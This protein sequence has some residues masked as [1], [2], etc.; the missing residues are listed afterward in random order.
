MPWRGEN[1]EP[2]VCATLL[3]TFI[4]CAPQDTEPV[5]KDIEIRNH[6]SETGT[7]NDANSKRIVTNQIAAP[8]ADSGAP[9]IDQ[10]RVRSLEHADCDAI[11]P[12][13]LQVRDHDAVDEE[14]QPTLV[15]SKSETIFGSTEGK[16]EAKNDPMDTPTINLQSS[17]QTPNKPP[18]V[19]ETRVESKVAPG[20]IPRASIS[21][22][23]K[24][25]KLIESEKGR[26]TES[27]LT[28]IMAPHRPFHEQLLQLLINFSGKPVTNAQG[29]VSY[30][31][32]VQSRML[33]DEAIPT[34]SKNDS[35]PTRKLNTSASTAA[36]THSTHKRCHTED[37]PKLRKSRT[38][39]RPPCARDSWL[40]QVSA[41]SNQGEASFAASPIF[42]SFQTT[43]RSGKSRRK[44]K[45]SPFTPRTKRGSMLWGRSRSKSPESAR[46]KG[47]R[48]RKKRRGSVPILGTSRAFAR[49]ATSDGS[50]MS[51][52]QRQTRLDL[53]NS[54]GSG[55]RSESS[56]A[57]TDHSG[58]SQ[59]VPKMKYGG[60]T[61]A[62]ADFAS[63]FE[64]PR[65][66]CS[67]D[68]RVVAVIAEKTSLSKQP[69]T[70]TRHSE[71]KHI[72]LATLNAVTGDHSEFLTILSV[73]RKHMCA[74]RALW[75]RGFVS[76][77]LLQLRESRDFTVVG[78]VLSSIEPHV[79]RNGALTLH[80]WTNL[81][82]TLAGQ[83]V[84]RQD[85]YVKTSLRFIQY[86]VVRFNAIAKRIGPS[87]L[88]VHSASDGMSGQ[89]KL[90]PRHLICYICGRKYGTASL[91]IHIPQCKRVFTRRESRKRPKHR[92]PLPR[93]PLTWKVLDESAD[94]RAIETMNNLALN[95]FYEKA[96]H[97]C[98]YC[99]R[100]FFE[101]AFRVHARGCREGR[102]YQPVGLTKNAMRCGRLVIGLKPT[103]MAL[104]AEN[105]KVGEIGR[106][107]HKLIEQLEDAHTAS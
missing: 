98:P 40:R 74:L 9:M 38:K 17:I 10:P 1:A 30:R 3:W 21:Y 44:Q 39:K 34:D 50:W 68:D 19:K 94:L 18:S 2:R 89:S 48:G 65:D 26:L 13:T 20:Q 33:E 104:G 54:S 61:H 42:S 105:G 107:V 7:N 63:V 14:A 102:S 73:R 66:S 85:H 76:E 58:L 75:V 25:K 37:S 78:D 100:T 55:P 72:A 49:V 46:R 84:A 51:N 95:V 67:S 62:K 16:K 5:V 12:Q 83:L 82:P 87:P 88:D 56:K 23:E 43:P 28:S 31:F 22:L 81:V 90:T 53:G 91:R 52:L 93:P 29:C 47:R 27:Q 64:A 70:P 103:L 97:R 24:A 79:L 4:S 80:M 86:L 57:E 92:K 35:S 106:Y 99:Q 11:M 69:I 32:S 15:E 101:K 6:S 71:S 60:N 8:T 45:Q 36:A 96:L 59:S 77:M 41:D